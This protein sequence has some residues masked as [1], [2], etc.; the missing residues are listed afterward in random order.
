MAGV[1]IDIG[2][3]DGKFAYKLAREYP[4][5]FIVGI[6]PYHK[7]LAE[8]SRKIYKKPAKGGAPNALY[9]LANADELPDELNGVANQVFINFPWGSLLKWV[10]TA[11]EKFWGGIRRISQKG[12]RIDV[13]FGYT[14]EYEPHKIEMQGLPALTL[15][16]IQHILAPALE[17]LFFEMTA[18]EMLTNDALKTFP[19]GW[20][21]RLSYGKSRQFYHLALRTK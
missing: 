9:V 12:A 17:K 11:D 13:I 14:D 3:G 21:K 1:I 20:A 5:R 2:T 10:V 4:D 8:V 7:G 6:D 19:S 16:H 18:I 15:E